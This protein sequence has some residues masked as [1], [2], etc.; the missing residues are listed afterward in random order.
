MALSGC[1]GE[2]AGAAFFVGFSVGGVDIR[3][4]AFLGKGVEVRF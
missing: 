4:C 2:A 1:L 3:V